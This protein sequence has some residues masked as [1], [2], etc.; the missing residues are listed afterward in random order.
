M[1][2]FRLF[3]LISSIQNN[4]YF[5]NR[6][7]ELIWKE[8]TKYDINLSIY[9]K[10]NK[11]LENIEIIKNQYSPYKWYVPNKLNNYINNKKSLL[12]IKNNNVIDIKNIYNYGINISNYSNL[13]NKLNLN[14]TTN[15]NCSYFNF[16]LNNSEYILYNNN[17]LID[18]PIYGIYSITITSNDKNLISYQI[19]N[20]SKENSDKNSDFSTLNF[21]TLHLIL[22]I[23]LVIILFMFICHVVYKYYKSKKNNKVFPKESKCGK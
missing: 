21:S 15:Y 18:S 7:Y 13:E 3:I 22:V 20:L 5:P 19:L 23:I 10:N 11:N 16:K 4:K 9:D 6:E 8:N 14:L 2:F 12:F 17:L 1:L